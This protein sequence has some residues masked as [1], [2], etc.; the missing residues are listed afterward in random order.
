MLEYFQEDFC[1]L[2]VGQ[3]A[4]GDGGQRRISGQMALRGY[5][6]WG[7]IKKSQTTE[8]VRDYDFE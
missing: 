8:A 6:S 3:S 7:R 4:T 1:S 2:V 5:P